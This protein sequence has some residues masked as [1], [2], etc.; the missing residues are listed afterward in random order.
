MSFT[1]KIDEVLIVKEI[2]GVVEEGVT[3]PLKCTLSNETSSIVKYQKNPVGTEVLINEWIGNCIADSI[4]LT[5]PKYGICELPSEIIEKSDVYGEIDNTNSG[6]SFF[7]EYISNTAPC[8]GTMLAKASNKE[9][10]RLLLFDHLI[11]N[12]DRHNGNIIMQITA[13]RKVFFIDCSHFLTTNGVL[14]AQLNLKKELSM[15]EILNNHLMANRNTNKG[16]NLYRMLC[17]TM[18][19][20]E[21]VL[22]YECNQIQRKLSKGVLKEIKES[23][24]GVWRT[25]YTNKRISDMFEIL[26]YRLEHLE[27][28]SKMI[29]SERR[30]SI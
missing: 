18:G 5:I 19:Y 8:S 4:G 7:S 20:N 1:R 30:L 3:Y 21:K 9:T 13:D 6:T 27:D 15:S 23:I 29:I 22:F 11:K 25:A 28:I 2:N 24:P 10:E 14:H 16:T 26:Q 17:E 12:E